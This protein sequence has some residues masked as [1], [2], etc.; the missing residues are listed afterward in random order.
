MNPFMW[1]KRQQDIFESQREQVLRAYVAS[2]QAIKQAEQRRGCLFGLS[3]LLVISMIVY[4]AY[5]LML[6]LLFVL[7][8]LLFTLDGYYAQKT[9]LC[10]SWAFP[11]RWLIDEEAKQQGRVVM[12]V[13]LF[14]L[15]LSCSFLAW[16]IL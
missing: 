11:R 8:S 1:L 13:G 15:V 14:F 9:Q 2:E 4:D 10:M 16:V 6:P 3:S 5:S 7:A 12:I